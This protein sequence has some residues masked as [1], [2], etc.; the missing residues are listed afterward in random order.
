MKEIKGIEMKKFHT[1]E[2]TDKYFLIHLINQST[3]TYNKKYL[4]VS[5]HSK[6]YFTLIH[7]ISFMNVV[8]VKF[9]KS[10]R[11]LSTAVLTFNREQIKL[12]EN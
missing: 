9:V 10:T 8:F 12:I 1:I 6:M 11:Q 2:Q 5:G 4:H 7:I 3:Q